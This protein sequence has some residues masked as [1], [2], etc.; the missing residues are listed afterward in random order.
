MRYA[1][2]MLSTITRVYMGASFP[3]KGRSASIDP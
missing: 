1:S 3:R 2:I